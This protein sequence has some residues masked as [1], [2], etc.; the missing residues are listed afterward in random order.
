MALKLFLQ[1]LSE[2]AKSRHYLRKES[3]LYEN[4]AAL[5]NLF[6]AKQ[7]VCDTNSYPQDWRKMAIENTVTSDF[8]ST[9]LNCLKEHFGLPLSGVF[10]KVISVLSKKKNLTLNDDLEF[11]SCF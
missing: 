3:L 2:D 8:L 6:P 4:A 7:S 1:R 9:F 11:F 5:K 10:I